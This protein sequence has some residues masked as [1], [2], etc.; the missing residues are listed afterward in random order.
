LNIYFLD[1]NGSS[2]LFSHD[3]N[4]L[5]PEYREIVKDIKTRIPEDMY[6]LSGKLYVN[7]DFYDFVIAELKFHGFKNIKAKYATLNV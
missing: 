1:I 7:R 4:I 3:K 5:T 6:Y 2:L